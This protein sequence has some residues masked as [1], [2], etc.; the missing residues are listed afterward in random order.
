M[1]RA[2][3]VESSHL[4]VVP[5][6]EEISLRWMVLDAL[7]PPNMYTEVAM[8]LKPVA[9]ISSPLY[10]R[11]YLNRG[12]RVDDEACRRQDLPDRIDLPLGEDLVLGRPVT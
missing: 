2:T 9:S 3:G 7:N 6:T 8:A 5:R 12:F 4:I 11:R 1:T 10:P